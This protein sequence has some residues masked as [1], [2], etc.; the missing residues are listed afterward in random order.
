MRY[1]L[2]ACPKCGGDLA[3]KTDLTGPYIECIQCGAEL[4]PLQERLFRNLGYIPDGLTPTEAP[5][6]LAEGRRHSA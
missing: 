3:N 2:R 4:S 6:V 1:W 5:P